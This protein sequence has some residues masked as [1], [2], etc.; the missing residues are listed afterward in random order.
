MLRTFCKYF[1]SFNINALV[2][3]GR[4][5]ASQKVFKETNSNSRHIFLSLASKK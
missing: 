1:F 2:G 3:T 4:K 5:K